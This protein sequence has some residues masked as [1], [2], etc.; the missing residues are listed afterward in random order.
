MKDIN[1]VMLERIIDLAKLAGYKPTGNML[2]DMQ[3]ELMLTRFAY[4]IANE[5][6]PDEENPTNG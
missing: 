5:L 6:K 3:T 2:T 1:H 4:R